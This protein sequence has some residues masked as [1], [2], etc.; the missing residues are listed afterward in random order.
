MFVDAQEKEPELI[1]LVSAYY[2]NR[3][4]LPGLLKAYD[5][6]YVHQTVDRIHDLDE[7]RDKKAAEE[8]QARK[9][10]TETAAGAATSE[11]SGTASRA[12][13]GTEGA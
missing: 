1:G 6:T 9:A 5:L 13:P 2:A 10:A 8:E 7:A 3:E 11:G 12:G 4:V